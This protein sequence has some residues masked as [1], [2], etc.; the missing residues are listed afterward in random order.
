MLNEATD[1]L[2]GNPYIHHT[3]I[4]TSLI[5][6]ILDGAFNRVNSLVN[7]KDNSFYYAFRLSLTHT[8]YFQLAEFIFPSNNS[9]D[10]GR[11][12]VKSDYYFFV[13]HGQIIISGCFILR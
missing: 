7:V 6:G 13:F 3:D 12:N 5:T 8:E 2:T 4:D 9:T 1:M 10:L 11:A